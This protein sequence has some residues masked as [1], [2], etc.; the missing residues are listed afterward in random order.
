MSAGFSLQQHYPF[1]P[2]FSTS[3]LCVSYSHCFTEGEITDGGT[4][5][6]HLNLNLCN[7]QTQ[8]FPSLIH[9][10]ICAC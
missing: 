7:L 8:E 4:H 9:Q 5:L 3:V 2:Q 6:C 1:M 10:W